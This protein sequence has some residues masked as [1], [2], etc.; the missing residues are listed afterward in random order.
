MLQVRTK[1]THGTYGLV[2][3][4]VDHPK[5]F[6]LA[7]AQRGQYDA[8]GLTHKRRQIQFNV[9]EDALLPLGEADE[10]V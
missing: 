8:A 7:A 5:P 10:R 9:T 6:R 4:A 1:E 2:V 3:A